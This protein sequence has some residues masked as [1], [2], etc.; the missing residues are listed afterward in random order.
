M[1]KRREKRPTNNN[2]VAG[3]VFVGSVIVMGLWGKIDLPQI[4]GT[5]PIAKIES[6]LPSELAKNFN[7][8]TAKVVAHKSI[9]NDPESMIDLYCGCPYDRAKN[10]DWRTCGY[11]PRKNAERGK[12]LEWE[13]VVPA[14]FFGRNLEC[15]KEGGR[16]NCTSKSPLFDAFEGDLHNL[17]PAI[18]EL[19]GDRSDTLFGRAKNRKKLYGQC[20][21]FVESGVVEPPDSAKG[22]VAR[23]WFYMAQKYKFTIPQNLHDILVDWNVRFP[24][25]EAEREINH[26]IS[27]HQ[28]D[29]NTFVGW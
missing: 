17:R 22:Q 29:R 27:V 15:W 4:P 7:F 16:K 18:G 5:N 21:F 11:S 1:R 10:I 6:Q 19:N 14:A 9:F 26:R 24:V 13:H 3:L 2:L 12:R 28:G 25:T 23:I 20:E 8:R